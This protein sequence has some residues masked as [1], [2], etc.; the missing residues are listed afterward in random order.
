MVKKIDH[1]QNVNFTSRSSRLADCS[2]EQGRKR[3]SSN[4]FISTF[5]QSSRGMHEL[6]KGLYPI[7]SDHGTGVTFSR[8]PVKQIV[9]AESVECLFN[10]I[11]RSVLNHFSSA[12][13][14]SQ[15]R[16][17]AGQAHKRCSLHENSLVI[18]KRSTKR[19]SREDRLACSAVKTRGHLLPS[20]G[21]Q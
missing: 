10:C 20:T 13:T 17:N 16:H 8:D 12:L 15:L 14:Q 11:S 3:S 7:F 6:E 2:D 5:N 4:L 19:T 21:V 1:L 18:K 9:A